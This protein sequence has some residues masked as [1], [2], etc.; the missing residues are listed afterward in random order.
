MRKTTVAFL[1][2]SLICIQ[3]AGA[4]PVKEDEAKQFAKNWAR[5][6]WGRKI[7]SISTKEKAKAT[8][9]QINS[10]ENIYYI[11]SFPQ[12]GWMIISGDD[13]AY[14]VIA[15]SPTGTYSNQNRPI[16]F[17]DWMEN[18]KKEI[19][20]AIKAKHAPLPKAEAA[21]KHFKD[22]TAIF[23]PNNLSSSPEEISI[24]ATAGPLLSTT[25]SQG[26]Y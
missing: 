6:K 8:V 16:Q 12:G 14:P 2:L 1:I 24:M 9:Q 23:A 4:K 22:S 20:G 25:W 11:L 3:N 13:V 7:D 10:E 18:V 26:K 21:W 17:E 5:E 19:T 15:F